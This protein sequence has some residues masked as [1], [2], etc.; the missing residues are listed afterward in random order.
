AAIQDYLN[1][2]DVT[3]DELKAEYDK[4]IGSAKTEYKARHI[5]LK[6]EEEAKN[7]IDK[8]NKGGDF[9]ALAKELSTG[10]SNVNGGDLGWFVPQQMVPPFSEA[11]IALEDGKYTSEPVQTN[12]GWHVILREASRTQEAPSF[13]SVKDQ[14]KPMLQREKLQQYLTDLR[15]AAEIEVLIPLTEEQA[16]PEAAAETPA[17]GEESESGTV[18]EAEEAS[19]ENV[20]EPEEAGEAGESETPVETA[21]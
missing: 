15:N 13:D 1:T 3:E 21:E 5:L 2:N 18:E 9:E 19:E 7:V 12:F 14:L 6:T 11:V 4:K 10:P 8:L 20:S 17:S 16:E